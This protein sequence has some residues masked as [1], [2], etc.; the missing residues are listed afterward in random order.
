MNNSAKKIALAAV[1]V[2]LVSGGKQALLIIPNV[3]VVSILLAVAGFCLGA[4]FSV[5]VS[6][7]FCAIETAIWGFNTWVILYLIYWPSLGIF[8]ALLKRVGLKNKWALA[9]VAAAMT[10]LFGILSTLLDT[11]VAFVGGGFV[12]NGTDFFIRFAILYG[13]GI[14]FFAIHIFSNFFMFAFLFKPL[15]EQVSRLTHKMMR[16]EAIS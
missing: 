6:F 8:F 5:S 16:G 11:L 10:F 3:E 1:F 15:S 2:A 14:V 7:A 4:A 9:A 12:V 13:R